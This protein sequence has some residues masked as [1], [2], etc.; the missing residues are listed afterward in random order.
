MSPLSHPSLVGYL[1][2]NNISR[3]TTKQDVWVNKVY[4]VLICLNV[5]EAHGGIK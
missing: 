4:V 1:A 5:D 2:F 3:K